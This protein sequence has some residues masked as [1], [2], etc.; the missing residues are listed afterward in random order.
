M[1]N[2]MNDL[3]P[4]DRALLDLVRESHEPT[5]GD[6]GRVRRALVL[7]LGVGTGLAGTTTATSKVATAFAF[8]KMLAAVAVAGAIGG[9]GAVA[10]WATKPAPQPV[11]AVLSARTLEQKA[12]VP[13]DLRSAVLVPESSPVATSQSPIETPPRG[14]LAIIPKSAPRMNEP[15]AARTTP[16]LS[17]VNDSTATL[18]VSPVSEVTTAVA[19]DSPL[20]AAREN[21]PVP[22][23][24]T[25]PSTTAV[26]APPT[27]LEA[28]TRLVRAGVSAL[29]AG[30]A[31]RAL[32]LFDEHA[33][34]FP[35]GAL[36][37]ERAAERVIALASLH[38]C[39]QARTAAAAFLR[40]HPHSPLAGR[41][42]ERCVPASN[43]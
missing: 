17:Q 2:P 15:A 19:P 30:D 41:V 5:D 34:T 4:E 22:V 8:T 40:E 28:E 14:A 38:R 29:H 24:G 35:D 27:T 42:R 10:Y 9:T 20:P 23:E 6:R 18:A 13:S 21:A 39:E 3:N 25:A 37:E 7:R 32:A 11:A 12:P 43:P 36:A 1:E 31:A 26:L 33:R 16:T